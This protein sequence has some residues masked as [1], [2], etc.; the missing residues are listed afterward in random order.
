[1]DT[2]AKMLKTIPAAMFQE[3]PALLGVPNQELQNHSNLLAGSESATAG[4]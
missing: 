1:M 4:V 3:N 2:V